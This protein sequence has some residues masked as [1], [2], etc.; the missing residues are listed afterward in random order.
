MH[1]TFFAF[2]RVLVLTIRH[3]GLRVHRSGAYKA[4]QSPDSGFTLVEVVVSSVILLIVVLAFSSAFSYVRRT[5]FSMEKQQAGLHAARGVME[6]FRALAYNDARLAI[7]NDLPLPASF[8]LDE[9]FREDGRYSV[10]EGGTPGAEKNITVV[11]KWSR[12]GEAEK[13]VSLTTT[14]SRMLH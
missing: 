14:H 1:G 13:S 3:G 5:V 7:G 11:I 12:P 9:E 6:Q 2:K 10:T 8:R 4:S